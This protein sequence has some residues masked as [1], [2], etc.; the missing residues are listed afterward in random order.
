MMWLEAE[1]IWT[2]NWRE[3]HWK[4]NM[5]ISNVRFIHTHTLTPVM[6][7]NT[8]SSTKWYCWSIWTDMKAKRFSLNSFDSGSK[9]VCLR[10]VLPF[11]IFLFHSA[12]GGVLLLIQLLPLCQPLCMSVFFLSLIPN[13]GTQSKRFLPIDCYYCGVCV[14]VYLCIVCPPPLLCA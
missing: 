12:G 10:M 8:E 11:V 3:T 6:Q 7:I 5:E 14:F 2:Q 13:A 9:W 4:T 1:K